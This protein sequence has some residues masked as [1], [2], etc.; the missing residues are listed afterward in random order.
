MTSHHS[1]FENPF[2]QRY[3]KV[4]WVDNFPF[5]KD[6]QD[7]FFQNNAIEE[8]QNVFIEPNNIQ[9]RIINDDNLHI[10]ELGFGFGLNFFVT[11]KLWIEHKD[12]SKINTLEYVSIEE[13]LPT[14]EQILRVIEN[15]PSLKPICQIFLDEYQPLHNDIN[16]IYLE[17]L[18][19]RLTLIHDKVETG[20][21]NLLGL[22]NN[23]IHAWYF[24]GFDPA[25]NSA[26]W[27]SSIFQNIGFLSAANSSF[28]TFTSAG[29]VKRNLSKFGFKVDRV[30]GFA[31]KRHK[32][33]GRKY[34]VE[35][36]HASRSNSEM[37]IA[38]IGTGISACSFAAA[39]A[40]N[41]AS[42]EM[43]ECSNIIAA[44]ASGNPVAALY[45]RFSA[46]STPYAFLTA[47]SYFFAEKIYSKIPDAYQ[48]TGL[49]FSH[50][51]DY[52]SE[53]MNDMK[54]LSRNDIFEF[55]SNKQMQDRYGLN[56]EGVKVNQGG[57]LYPKL[58]C[59]ALMA[60]PNIKVF[61]GH[62]FT[63]WQEENSKITV[64]FKDQDDRKNYDSL[65]MAHGPGLTEHLSGLKV[66]KGQLVGLK[67]AQKI[68]LDLP[69]NSAGYILPC[70]DGVTW[71]GSTHEREFNNLETSMKSS[72]E[73]IKRTE[74]NFDFI[75]KG[76]QNICMKARLRIGSKDRLPIAGKIKKNVYAIGG[77]GSRGFSLG[78]IL[79]EYIASLINNSPSPISTGL[80][81]SI[82]PLRF[83]D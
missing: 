35:T 26:M 75:I 69:L 5:S 54:Q 71:I 83:K 59:E 22:P 15:F 67:E 60:H 82:D 47:Q 19:L 33:I 53:W 46:N 52:L 45:P 50:P 62:N 17:K 13:A 61:K 63:N 4:E 27:S 72:Q 7:R 28:G 79:G 34:S 51:N 48:Q 55:L 8:I 57:Y 74:E 32:L 49:L 36:N 64:S 1:C 66:S 68:N 12:R 30:K 39:A 38:V 25:K 44:G 16:R 14:E 42:V 70:C 41:G 10:G 18:D 9:H 23:K 21:K 65:V 20:L 76:K 56:S 73:L 31:S 29:S 77:L 40:K 37:Q 43:F 24:D 80:A 81:L 3:Q 58:I 6:Y 2:E 11:A 78:P